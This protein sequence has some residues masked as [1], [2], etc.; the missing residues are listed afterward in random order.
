M[1][2]IYYLKQAFRAPSLSKNMLTGATIGLALIGLFLFKADAPDPEWPR[3]WM[4]RP[5]LI[6]PF[7]GAMGGLFFTFMEPWRKKSGWIKAAAYIICLLVT[8]AGLF[9]GIVL[10]LDGTYWN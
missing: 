3:L 6:V 1:K 5:L 10:G 7:A 4:L 2:F 8:L 9:M